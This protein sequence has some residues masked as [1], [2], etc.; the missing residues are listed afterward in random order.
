MGYKLI[1]IGNSP[2]A[3]TKYF[4]AD[5]ISD[6]NSIPLEDVSFGSEC[7][8]IETGQNFILN[9][10][11]VWVDQTSGSGTSSS[12]SGSSEVTTV[13]VPYT[14]ETQTI[15]PYQ[16]VTLTTFEESEEP[17]PMR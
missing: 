17:T 14:I 16:E 12:S 1:T 4:R 5:T 7:L 10:S 9:S 11:Q 3:N 15:F 13:N 6:M 8:V 2:N